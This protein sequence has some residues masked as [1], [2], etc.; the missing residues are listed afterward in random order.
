MKIIQKITVF[1][2]ILLSLQLKAQNSLFIDK[3][4]VE[5]AKE[6]VRVAKM[7]QQDS[8]VDNVKWEKLFMTDGYRYYLDRKDSAQMKQW[9]KEAMIVAFDKNRKKE[10]DSIAAMP[11]NLNAPDIIRILITQ[12]FYRLNHKLN[13]IAACLDTIDFVGILEQAHQRTQAFLPASAYE[14]LPELNNIYIIGTIPDANVRG[15]HV[16]LD[17][18]LLL[19]F[20]TEQLI[21]VLAHEFHHNYRDMKIPGALKNP[22][23]NVINSMHAEGIADLIDKNGIP[24]T[25]LGAYGSEM[26]ELY[27]KDF[28]NTPQTLKQIDSIVQSYLKNEI[29]YETYAQIA[30]MIKFGGH[31]CGFYMALLIKNN[32]DIQEL[33]D[34]YD[35]PVIFLQLYN[36][37]ATKSD[38]E[39]V[40][41]PEFML[42]I[43]QLWKEYI[44]MK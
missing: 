42:H 16:F 1:L 6:W 26:L 41:S 18:S 14:N 36:N 40:F 24:F 20:T 23:L 35:N 38:R 3:Y 9:V 29:N 33:I 7:L 17:L 43:E 25:H 5:S 4:F 12:N 31:T 22:L 39:H 30:K 21:N 27:T 34:S 2:L 28:L 37:A 44:M 10:A 8:H 13:N 11:I 19:D 15:K 32:G